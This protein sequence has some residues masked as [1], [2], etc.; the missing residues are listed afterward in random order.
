MVVP[1]V[2]AAVEVE[3]VEVAAEE[4]EGVVVAVVVVVDGDIVVVVASLAS[5]PAT[6][7]AASVP[8]DAEVVDR[9]APMRK[10]KKCVPAR[11]ASIE[12]R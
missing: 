5:P 10:D 1:V 4:V 3:V 2:G 11:R 6:A 9:E 8:E 7:F 12:R